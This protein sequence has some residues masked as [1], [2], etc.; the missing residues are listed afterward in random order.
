MRPRSAV[1]M[2]RTML[3]DVFVRA[4]DQGLDEAARYLVRWGSEGVGDRLDEQST[5][6][7][8]FD[9][10]GVVRDEPDGVV[11]LQPRGEPDPETRT[12]RHPG[13]TR[14]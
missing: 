14:G 13:A 8:L 4:D 2:A 6:M 1:E 11:V 7:L 12:W 3:G 5:L 9:L 10:M